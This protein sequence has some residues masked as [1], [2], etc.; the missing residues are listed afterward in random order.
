MRHLRS[1]VIKERITKLPDQAEAPHIFNYPYK[2]IEESL[3]NAVYHRG[4]DV[5]EPIE[6]RVNPDTIEILSY[7]GPDPSI[8]PE[9]LK[10]ARFLSRRYRNR[11]IGEFLKELDLTEGRF[12]G[13]PKIRQAMRQNGSPPPTFATD[14]ERT[15]FGVELRIHPLFLKAQDAPI[16][17]RV[18]AGVEAGVEDQVSI[19]T[20]TELRI[21]RALLPGPRA[22]KDI[23]TALGHKTAS[24][25]LRKALDRLDALGLITLTIPDRPQSRRQQRRLTDK[26]RGMIQLIDKGKG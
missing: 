14:E 10:G 24:G 2:A 20:D 7:P 26:G 6:V 13:I 5:R 16:E 23:V 25:N 12:T 1:E 22:V 21:L 3:V 11:R 8:R 15:F 18:K 17:A 19:F 9:D 4:Y